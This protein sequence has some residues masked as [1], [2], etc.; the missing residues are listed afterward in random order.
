MR[1]I[2]VL[3]LLV[4]AIASVAQAKPK[5]LK[6]DLEGFQ[7]VP[8][9]SSTGGGHFQ[10]TLNSTETQLTYTVTFDDL[11]APVTQS[12]IHFA[13]KGVNGAIVIFLCSNLGNGPAGTQACPADGGTISGTISADNVLAVTPQ[14]I[15]AGALPEVVRAIRAG[16]A[17]VNVHSTSFP[18]GEIRG[19]IR[20][21]GPGDKDDDAAE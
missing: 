17:Y 1:K 18:G 12:H 20:F 11:E 3:A 10:G 16:N 14:G 5:K 2:V 9:I 4:A 15:E 21:G 6:A 8:A 13:Q 7:E 19:Q